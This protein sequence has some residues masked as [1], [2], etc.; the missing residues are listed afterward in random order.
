TVFVD[1]VLDFAFLVV[2]TT[3]ISY[4]VL[5]TRFAD[6][7]TYLR[8]GYG[9]LGLVL[10]GSL[11]LLYEGRV[12]L[13]P[14]AVRDTLQRFREGAASCLSRGNALPVLGYTLLVWL[15]VVL[16]VYVVALALGVDIGVALAGF[17]GLFM[18]MLTII[19]LTPAGLGAVELLTTGF[20][21]LLGMEPAAVLSIVLLDRTITYLSLVVSGGGY[22]LWTDRRVV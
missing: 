8:I 4:A 14:D 9:F 21:T 22:Y 11:A 20:L 7:W 10:L 16:R 12:R 17:I 2:S 18:I 3:L 5:S 15:F 6:A 1:R 19:P 13:L